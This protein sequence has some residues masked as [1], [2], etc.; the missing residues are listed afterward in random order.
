VVLSLTLVG[1]LE[2]PGHARRVA[3]QSIYD[4]PGYILQS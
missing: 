2:L 4:L 1:E 3:A